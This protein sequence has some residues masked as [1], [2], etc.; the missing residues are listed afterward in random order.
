M[1]DKNAI[2]KWKKNNK[3]NYY[4]SKLYDLKKLKNYKNKEKVNLNDC[5]AFLYLRS[6]QKY[7]DS[8]KKS[9]PNPGLTRILQVTFFYNN[10]LYLVELF[11]YKLIF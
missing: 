9:Y 7:F 10:I 4:Y 6:L 5:F 3:I 8:V 2:N 11:L 1:L